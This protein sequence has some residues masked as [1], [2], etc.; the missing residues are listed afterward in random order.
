MSDD[1]DSLPSGPLGD[2]RRAPVPGPR[3]EPGKTHESFVERL[4]SRFGGEIDPGVDL[5]RVDDD[6]PTADARSSLELV[7]KLVQGGGGLRYEVKREIARGGMGTILR[8]W[9]D[10]LRRNLA[11]KV[12]HAKERSGED[13]D[14]T[15][16]DREKL[17]R[18]LEEAQITGQLDHPGIVP[19]HD[20]GIDD[21]GRCYF[22]MRLVRGREL[23]DVLDDTREGNGGWTRT[24]A[25]SLL[26]KVC[27]TMAF[28]HAK[29][30]VHRDL[31]PSNV[32]V[33]RYGEV[34]VMD[35]GLARIV[36]QPDKHDLRLRKPEEQSSL[37]LV[38]TVRKDESEEDPDS[39]LVTMDG[40][41]VGTPS[42]MAVEQAQ[43][44]LEE[45]GP[46][47]DVYSLGAILYYML[48]GKAPYV[49][50]GERVSPHTVL[51]RVL[52]GPP[53]PVAKLARN[54][55]AELIAICEKAMSR[56]AARRYA[57]MEEVAD[58]LQAYIED[59]VVSAYEGGSLA[60]FKKWVVRNRGVATALCGMVLLAFASALGF[61]FQK[62]KRVTELAGQQARVN[63]A[64]EAAVD[65]AKA[66]E[67][68]AK[69]ARENL[70]LARQRERESKENYD[71]AEEKR[72]EAERSGYAANMTAADYS[73]RLDD[74]EEARVRL[75]AA[76]SLL[77]EWEWW[78]LHLRAYPALLTIDRYR[79]RP[80]DQIEWSADGRTLYVLSRDGL[81]IIDARDGTE[82]TRAVVSLPMV[83]ATTL[84]AITP[85]R[86]SLSPD[87]TRVVMVGVDSNVRVYDLASGERTLQMPS[88]REVV[89]HGARTSTVAFSPDGR[90]I[91]SGGDNGSVLLWDADGELQRR[92]PFHS[93]AV[94]DLA[95]SSDST[96]FATASAD[97]TIRVWDAASGQ[98]AAQLLGHQGAVRGVVWDDSGRELFS[99]GADGIVNR[100]SVES[101][102]LIASFAGHRDAVCALDHDP[103]SGKLVTCSDDRTIRVWDLE[104]GE[105]SILLGSQA[106]VL[107]ASFS[108]DGALIFSSA[109]DGLIKQWDSR[110]DLTTTE[111]ELHEA[112]VTSTAFRGDGELV[113]SGDAAGEIVLWD[114]LAGEPLRRL[115]GHE[116]AIV[117]IAFDPT[118]EF[119]YSA[120]TDGTVRRWSS[121]TGALDGL[122][123]H[124]SPV[125]GLLVLPDGN[126]ILT[127]AGDRMV[128]VYE[129][130]SQLLVREFQGYR[131]PL[132]NLSLHPD[133]EIF[134]GTYRN[135]LVM[136]RLDGTPSTEEFP[137]LHGQSPFHDA[138]FTPNGEFL[139]TALSRGD[140][141]K[142]PFDVKSSA[143]VR[144]R[145]HLQV[146]GAI[147]VHPAGRR[148]ASGSSDGTIRIRDVDT[149]ESILTLSWPRA[150]I[151]TL[152]YSPD[153]LRLL[154]GTKEGW[155]RAW[156][157]GDLHKR[158]RRWIELHRLRESA[159]PLVERLFDER[160]TVREVRNALQQDRSMT[161]EE[162]QAALRLANL[163]GD[164]PRLLYER[165]LAEVLVT[166]NDPQV[167][168][169]AM[170]RAEAAHAME[171]GGSIPAVMLSLGVA[172]Y[173]MGL[174]REALA[175]LDRAKELSDTNQ[176]LEEPKSKP[177]TAPEDSIR[178]LFLAMAHARTGR[179][180]LARVALSEAQETIH[181]HP[182]LASYRARLVDLVTEAEAMLGV[183]E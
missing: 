155:I 125:T 173:R 102:S 31:K 115:R 62:Q 169:H 97:G 182:D 119:L 1:H 26:L 140:V 148:F 143:A 114:A 178:L 27:E 121:S 127:A 152:A 10:D 176:V 124:D 156:E 3:H 40:D 44:R 77:R 6:E 68:S 101:A 175:S 181:N 171:G 122:F 41:V 30:V 47:S 83:A 46:R 153:G 81:K 67:S 137:P 166:G 55:P 11:M 18:F 104:R 111:F 29:G 2:R 79:S 123:V 110:G 37:S 4:S 15:T 73:L 63:E 130:E 74:V 87:E 163:R 49:E 28:A 167:Y 107:D 86:M 149:I 98:Q 84:G 180:N 112:E 12:L 91:A 144:K 168:A 138:A 170:N 179:E 13:S 5:Q 85:M 160:F 70:E 8:V 120:S 9:D 100:W 165:T 139:L 69:Q 42:F 14:A 146:A 128:R 103:V 126:R 38:R 162:R 43:G 95:W 21:R 88:Q 33:G 145:D 164:D 58:D 174:E 52:S 45:V 106:Q 17:G 147:A 92:F 109:E 61:A 154:A 36:G 136:N 183:P 34:Y 32:M 48:T 82:L 142:W 7:R 20:L 57:S 135:Y 60:E 66:A 159:R 141:I 131:S 53:E 50:K 24:K 71:L 93:G 64:R 51:N 96:R 172:Q 132:S 105:V 113:A 78:Y 39:P 161:E 25:L 65:S 94:T 35:W 108:P 72:R 23:K 80:V 76:N 157:T 59:R 150:S 75:S 134:A 22:T 56:E 158:R 16:V 129:A 90:S 117:E 89:G 99:G 151:T 177:L 54:Q 19:V 133:G 116:G 118:G